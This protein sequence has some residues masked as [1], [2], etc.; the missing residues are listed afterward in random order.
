M[1]GIKATKAYKTRQ[2]SYA[3]FLLTHFVKHGHVLPTRVRVI[4]VP[5]KCMRGW[6]S[7]G[8]ADAV[9]RLLATDAASRTLQQHNDPLCTLFR[10]ETVSLDGQALF[11]HPKMLRKKL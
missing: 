10:R 2:I 7:G 5:N 8:E 11:E 9:A 6:Q 3:F 1:H 4:Q